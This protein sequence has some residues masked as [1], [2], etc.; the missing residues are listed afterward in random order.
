MHNSC[1]KGS[2]AVPF[3]HLHCCDVACFTSLVQSTQQAPHARH[4]RKRE[5][6]CTLSV[7][8]G[9]S[10]A[11]RERTLSL[12]NCCP[13]LQAEQK[14]ET[15]PVVF[16]VRLTLRIH[17]QVRFVNPNV[18]SVA[19]PKHLSPFLSPYHPSASSELTHKRQRFVP[20]NRHC[21]ARY[22]Q[23]TIGQSGEFGA[24]RTACRST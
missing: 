22:P 17:L 21:Y 10:R 20:A 15:P 6:L 2:T 14:R 4:S 5:A 8:M 19:V 11:L 13:S 12:V 3:P 18:L 1:L 9:E 16:G 23:S 24:S 7:D